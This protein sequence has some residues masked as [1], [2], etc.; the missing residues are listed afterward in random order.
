MS[1]NSSDTKT[2]AS[3]NMLEGKVGIVTGAGQGVGNNDDVMTAA[4][5]IMRMEEEYHAARHALELG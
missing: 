2:E 1:D 4:D 5:L 3:S